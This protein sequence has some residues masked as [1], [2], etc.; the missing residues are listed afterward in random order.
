MALMAKSKS[1]LELR[2]Q[3]YFF[4]YVCKLLGRTINLMKM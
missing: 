2:H 3:K 4:H 1:D